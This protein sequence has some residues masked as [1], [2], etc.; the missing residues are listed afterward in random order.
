M[1]GHCRGEDPHKGERM[2]KGSGS[3][4]RICRT[5]AIRTGI[6]GC[7]LALGAGVSSA[8]YYQLKPQSGQRQ[9]L[10]ASGHDS[11]IVTRMTPFELPA[12]P[13]SIE[14]TYHEPMPD[15][16]MPASAI[17]VGEIKIQMEDLEDIVPFIEKYAHQ[18]GAD[19]I[20]SFTEPKGY[21]SRNGDVYYRATATLIK[22]LDPTF[23]EQA[24]LN[25]TYY[26]DQHM[27]NYADLQQYLDKHTE[28]GLKVD[29]PQPATDDENTGQ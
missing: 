7:L 29:R 27:Q 25:Y 23:I 16:I 4:I 15:S 1:Q 8:Q 28:F 3:W 14:L 21:K 26:E 22:V 12:V 5:S 19:W 24:K 13:D 9:I 6:I 2:K 10:K 17:V 11:V 18:A 20:V